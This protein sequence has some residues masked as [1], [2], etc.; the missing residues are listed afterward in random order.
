[1]AEASLA[2]LQDRIAYRFR[3]PELL[4]EALT[5]SSHVQERARGGRDNQLMEFLGDAVLNFVVTT[6]LVRTFPHFDEGELSQVR[7]NLVSAPH[8]ARVATLLNLGQYL[9]LGPAEERT[10]GREKSGILVDAVEALVAAVY[11]DGGLDSARALVENWILPRDLEQAVTNLAPT[12]YK[13]VLQE[14][15]QAR[16]RGPAEY[17]VVEES[18]LEHQKIFVVEVRVDETLTARGQGSSK[19]AAEQQAACHALGE[20]RKR[21]RSGD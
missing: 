1:M 14:Y 4:Q 17:K 16:R 19:K 10:G 12:N 8:L 11:C 9:R 21:E 15:L 13:G 7:A 20:L 5:H 2:E 6:H 18:G 3:N